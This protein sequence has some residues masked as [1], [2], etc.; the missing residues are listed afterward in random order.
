ML[1][2]YAN[3]RS[4]LELLYAYCLQCNAYL[5]MLCYTRVKLGYMLPFMLYTYML[6]YFTHAYVMILLCY[7]KRSN[8]NT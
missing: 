6:Q 4:L 5:L 7:V 8:P 2:L 1:C 3:I